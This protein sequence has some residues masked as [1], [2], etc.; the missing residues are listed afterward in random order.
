[1]TKI[2]SLRLKIAADDNLKLA[3]LRLRVAEIFA[4]LGSEAL[5]AGEGESAR[6]HW[7][8]TEVFQGPDT[9]AKSQQPR[10]PRAV[11]MP[12]LTGVGE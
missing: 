5:D 10:R 9:L 8:T 6:I 7:A 12:M 2:V 11:R 1:M 3:A 4:G